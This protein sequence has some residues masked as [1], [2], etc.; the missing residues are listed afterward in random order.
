MAARSLSLG[1]AGLEPM[2]EIAANPERWNRIQAG[3]AAKVFLRSEGS[4]VALAAPQRVEAGLAAT[5]AEVT[6]RFAAF[7]R[8]VMAC[9]FEHPELAADFLI[10]PLLQTLIDLDRAAPFADPAHRFDCVLDAHGE[11]RVIENNSVAV[12]LYHFRTLL[13]LIRELDRGG[14]P[15]AARAIEV[16]VAELASGFRRF[17]VAS[18][19][20]PRERPTIGCLTPP[21]WLRAGQ[22]LFRAAFERHGFDYVYGDPTMLEVTRTGV[23]LAG[24]SID[25]LWSDFLLYIAY[26]AERY[27]ETRFPSKIGSYEDT[28]ETVRRLVGNPLF[29]EHL[30]ERRVINL[31]P[32]TAYLGLPK[33]LLGWIHRADRP[34]PE[35]ERAWL[36]RH[37][38]RTYLVEDRQDGSLTLDDAVARRDELLLKPCQY[39]GSHGVTIGRDCAAAAWAAQVREVWDDRSWVLQ[40]FVVPA[41]TAAG[42]WLS[43]GLSSFGGHLGGVFLRTSPSLIVNARDAAFLPAILP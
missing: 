16:S 9:Y 29:I 39:G 6:S 19:P 25:L 4:S 22:L 26:Q 40:D 13:Y 23:R 31:S 2:P 17:Y 11:V 36:A 21:R 20:A 1:V 38:A 14:L 41:R 27:R 3:L 42:Q 12:C 5:F 15:D 33:L 35:P 28:P 43:I 7:Y 32:G 8:H 18:Q 37:V 30:R 10:N 24:R 34:V